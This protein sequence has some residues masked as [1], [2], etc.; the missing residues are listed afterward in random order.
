MQVLK[1]DTSE[2]P[3]ASDM[4]LTL[5]IRT[6]NEPLLPRLKSFECE[7]ATEAFI[8]FIPLFFSPQTTEISISFAEDPPTV[9]VASMISGF[10]TLCPD[11][12][13][14][15][16]EGLPRDTV[17]IGAV[18]EMLLA[19]NPGSLQT[20]QMDSPLTEEAREV[21]YKL[22]RLTDL[23]AIIQGSTSL[24]T[25]TLPNLTAVGVEFEDDLD[26]L[27]GFRGVKFDKLES[28]TFWSYSDPD[29]DFPR[30]FECVA[31]AA[32]A[33]NILSTFRYYTSRSWNP[34]YR[35]L[36][37]FKQL[38]ELEIEFSCSSGCSSTVDDD[39]IMNIARAMPKLEILQLGGEPCGTS[40][41][42]TVGGLFALASRCPNLTKLCIHFQAS[43]L[44]DAATSAATASVVDDNPVVRKNDC[45]LTD[46]VV[47]EAPIPEESAM[48]V[49]LVLLQIFPRILN[50][51]YTNQEWETVAETIEHF[52]QI[53]AFIRRS[54]ETNPSRIHLSVMT[55]PQQLTKD[56]WRKVAR[57]D[58]TDLILETPATLQCNGK[59][60]SF[61]AKSNRVRYGRMRY[62]KESTN[63][64]QAT[65][66][67]EQGP[68]AGSSYA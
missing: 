20:L 38:K 9:A 18:S 50:V 15:T 7:E 11:L 66:G 22:P 42:V 43:S 4:L 58:D 31:L 47:G 30:A 48:T 29:G 14:I 41:G 34:D 49:T 13:H 46:L 37:S 19:C 12:A 16:L 61:D 36:L 33:Q 40:T 67:Q 64:R 54:G 27:R 60:L 56:A 45:A 24:P 1:V 5:Q 59:I 23:W 63:A 55:P 2:D 26:W 39:I 57:H 17:I 68:W 8:P 10:P 65:V 51:D 21:V 28:V 3:V 53:G 32:S 35:S 62:R 44:V 25:V 6:A 52:G